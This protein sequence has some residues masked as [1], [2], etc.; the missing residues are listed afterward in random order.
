M[1]DAHDKYLSL[2]NVGGNGYYVKDAEARTA[3]TAVEGRVSTNEQDIVTLKA[4]V[5]D[6]A[7]YQGKIDLGDGKTTALEDGSTTNPV[8]IIGKT[9][10]VT[11]NAGDFV[12]QQATNTTLEFIWD[13]AAWREFGSTG[14]LKAFAYADTGTFT[15]TP[16]GSVSTGSTTVTTSTVTD[17]TFTGTPATLTGSFSGSEGNLSVSGTPSGTVS[18]PTFSGTKVEGLNGTFTGTQANLSVTG[19]P[20]GTV[21]TP[22]ITVELGTSSLNNLTASMG[23][24][25]TADA[26]TLTLTTTST[27]FATGSVTKAES[28]QPTFTGSSLEST[29]TFTPAGS[30]TCDDFTPAGTVSQPTFSGEALTSTGK[31]TPAGS[32]TMDEYTPAGTNSGTAVTLAPHNHTAEFTGTEA[33]VTVSPAS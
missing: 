29:G 28:T 30:V 2:V 15:Y 23:T 6:G 24:E 18:Q 11:V 9:A 21:S 26:E 32:I 12:T 14:K 25:G 10:A 16:A 5:K 19:T 33:T 8:W 3:I 13:G 22:T 31:F 4:A 1:T 7:H 27:T 17:P 20:A